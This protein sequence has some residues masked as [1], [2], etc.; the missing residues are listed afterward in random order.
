[1]RGRHD[2]INAVAAALQTIP[3]LAQVTTYLATN[4][5]QLPAANVLLDLERLSTFPQAMQADVP[6][7]AVAGGKQQHTQQHQARRT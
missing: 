1:M 6:V 4:S 5:W 2:I 3:D 7:Q